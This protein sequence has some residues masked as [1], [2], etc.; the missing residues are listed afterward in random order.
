MNEIIIINRSMKVASN[1]T[2]EVS[3]CTSCYHEEGPLTSLSETLCL[4]AQVMLL[5]LMYL[6]SVLIKVSN[7]NVFN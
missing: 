2:P 7:F 5:M 3:K 1:V 4:A 6:I